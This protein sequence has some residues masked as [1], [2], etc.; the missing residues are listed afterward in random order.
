M[1]LLP[2][3]E[4]GEAW[5]P[6]NKAMLCR[7]SGSIGQ[8]GTFLPDFLKYIARHLPSGYTAR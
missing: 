3:G 1:L 4:T 6:S 7:K 5:E 2:E 8:Q